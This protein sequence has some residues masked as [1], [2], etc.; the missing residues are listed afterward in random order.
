[1]EDLEKQLSKLP[2]AKLG[3]RADFKIKF[4]IYSLV[5]SKN[6]QKFAKIFFHPHSLIAKVSLT[7]LAIF[8]VLGATAVYAAN[9]DQITPGSILYPLKKTVENVEQQ[10]SLTKSAKVENFNKLSE[11]RLKEALNLAW[12]DDT[13]KDSDQ[14]AEVNNNIE[15]SIA[16]A[17]NNF[18][19]AIETSQ[20]IEDTNDSQK[21]RESLKQKQ[22]SM[23]KYLDNISDIAKNKKDEKMVKKINEAKEAIGKYDQMLEQDDG[24]IYIEAVPDSGAGGI[25][26]NSRDKDGGQPDNAENEDESNARSTNDLESNRGSGQD[27]GRRD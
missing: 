4:K 3:E 9:N 18:D 23:V 11:R 16:E 14:T 26:K 2:Q 6:L 22:E 13:Q 12:Q 5:L 19:S 25:M 1:M 7:V 10:L 27:R 20:K 8:V 15:Q 24:D 17:V 21:V